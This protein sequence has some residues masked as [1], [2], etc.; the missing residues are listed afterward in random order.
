MFKRPEKTLTPIKKA[1]KREELAN[2]IKLFKLIQKTAIVF[3]VI[4][5]IFRLSDTQAVFV[6]QWDGHNLF[7]MAARFTILY[8]EMVVVFLYLLAALLIKM[9]QKQIK[10]LRHEI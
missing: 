5:I 4:S 9:A 10:Q 1:Y 8:L 7:E 6:K 3:F 2:D